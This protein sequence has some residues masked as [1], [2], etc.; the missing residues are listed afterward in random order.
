MSEG[1]EQAISQVPQSGR[2]RETL[3]ISP[4]NV[5]TQDRDDRPFW[6]RTQAQKKRKVC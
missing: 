6:L 1:R 5:P 2:V 4:G 3:R